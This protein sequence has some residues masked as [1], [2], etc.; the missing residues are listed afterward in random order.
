MGAS[1]LHPCTHDE[2]GTGLVL[3]LVRLGVPDARPVTRQPLRSRALGGEVVTQR[4]SGK[5]V[6]VTDGSRPVGMGAPGIAGVGVS[7]RPP[8]V[9][10]AEGISPDVATRLRLGARQHVTSMRRQCV[11]RTMN[12][13]IVVVRL[14]EKDTC[15]LGAAAV[16]GSRRDGSFPRHA[17]ERPLLPVTSVVLK[18]SG[19]RTRTRGTLRF[20]SLS[21]RVLS[22]IR[23][24]LGRVGAYLGLRNPS[25]SCGLRGRPD[26]QSHIVS[27]IPP[28]KPSRSPSTCARWR[29]GASKEAARSWLHR[30]GRSQH[31]VADAGGVC[32]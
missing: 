3:R 10:I 28:A 26:R 19:D 30:C 29:H 8:A 16:P 22:E 25:G 32:R 31:F 11:P 6:T 17:Q 20:K 14:L 27:H 1:L 13:N 24:I 15:P 9:G 2:F 5:N 23:P 21:L 4:R 12:R 18:G 7:E